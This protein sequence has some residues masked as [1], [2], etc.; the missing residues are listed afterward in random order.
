MIGDGYAQAGL[1]QPDVR[2][3]LPILHESQ[4]AQRSNNFGTGKV[5]R[6]LHAK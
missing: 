6:K 3:F 2:T 1:E 4:T 5:A